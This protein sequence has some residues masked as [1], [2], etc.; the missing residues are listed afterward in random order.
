[1]L[2]M[3]LKKWASS[4][5]CFAKLDVWLLHPNA[6]SCSLK[7]MAKR[8]PVRQTYALLQSGQVSLYTPDR[9]NL[10]GV[11][12]LWESR[13]PMV[14]WCR[15]LFLFLSFWRG[16]KC[17]KFPCLRRWSW[18]T[19]ACV[20]GLLLVLLDF[21]WVV[22]GVWSERHYYI[23]CC[24]WCLAPVGTPLVSGCRSVLCWIF[25]ILVVNWVVGGMGDDGVCECGLPVCGGFN[26]CGGSVYGDVKIV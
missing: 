22:Y 9:E 7:D 18:S 8:L 15:M 3:G 16:W 26:V 11:G 25:V 23:E 6:F 5:R 17:R 21:G 10:L 20:F 4:L 2:F 24:G 12:F 19:F 1:M 14:F 13:F